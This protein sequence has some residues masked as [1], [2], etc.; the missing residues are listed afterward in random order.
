MPRAER[1]LAE[2]VQHEHFAGEVAPYEY[3]TSLT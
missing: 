1:T 2:A 3:I